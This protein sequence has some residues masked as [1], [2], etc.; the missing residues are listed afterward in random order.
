MNGTDHETTIE[1]KWRRIAD[2]ARS[3]AKAM[4]PCEK[5]ENLLKKATQLDV[6]ATLNSW[7][8]SPASK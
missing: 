7:L 5:R 8:S 2:E 3:E 6:A 4:P 1:Q